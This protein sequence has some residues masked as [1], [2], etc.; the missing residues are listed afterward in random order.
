MEEMALNKQTEVSD[1]DKVNII[2]MLYD[3]AVNFT[4]TAK[5]KVETGDSA[6][7]TL[8][9]RKSSAI[10][11][12]LLN[13]LNMDGGEVAQNLSKLYNFILDNLLK[14][15]M[16]N[17]LKAIEDAEKVIEILR[18]AWNEIQQAQAIGK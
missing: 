7:K 12:E 1:S 9:I 2:T 8:Y 17:D 15:D 5:E 13:S 4:R 3:G 6:G 18:D 14:A 10:V 11:K 16:Q